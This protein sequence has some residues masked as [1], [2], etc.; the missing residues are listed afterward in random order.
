MVSFGSLISASGARDPGV[1]DE[2]I[3]LAKIGEDL[4]ANGFHGYLIGHIHS[5][6]FG[7]A[8]MN[9]VDA[10]GDF[11]GICLRAA[12]AR[13]FGSF[14]GKAFGNGFSDAATGAGDN[15][16]LV[17][18]TVH[19]TTEDVAGKSAR[20]NAANREVAHPREKGPSPDREPGA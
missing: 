6:R 9:C 8:G 17:F 2:D 3:D 1:V 12:D 13:N 11:G 19:K 15:S 20:G 7:C 14:V 10:F 18:E 16:D 4:L 5:V